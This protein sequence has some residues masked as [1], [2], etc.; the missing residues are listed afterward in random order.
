MAIPLD[1]RAGLR[2]QVRRAVRPVPIGP[3]Q[4]VQ[5]LH[6]FAAVDKTGPVPDRETIP[7]S[8]PKLTRRLPTALPS[9]ANGVARRLRAGG[10]RSCAC[11]LARLAT[12]AE[13]PPARLLSLYENP[14][15]SLVTALNVRYSRPNCNNRNLIEPLSY[16]V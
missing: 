5:V 13:L 15:E 10:S 3:E 6:R 2:E 12:D 14:V 11:F 9:F 4:V 16:S 8:V 7:S 1:N